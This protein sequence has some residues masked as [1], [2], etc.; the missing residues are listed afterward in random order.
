M[1]KQEYKRKLYIIAAGLSSRMGGYPKHLCYIDEAGT[2]NLE[3]TLYFAK[4]FYDNIVIVINKLL[5]EEYVLKTKDIANKYNAEV[6]QIESG[7]GDGHAVYEAI[8]DENEFKYVTCIWGDTYFTDN[9]IFRIY[10]T[11]QV[12]NVV[13]ANEISPYCYIKLNDFSNEIESM[14]FA[15]EIPPKANTKYLHDQSTFFINVHNFKLYFD[16]YIKYCDKKIKDLLI[17][18][19]K[20]EYSIIKFVNWYNS[21]YFLD[22]SSKIC[23]HVLPEE[24]NKLYTISYNTKEE[25]QEILEKITLKFEDNEKISSD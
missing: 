14:M 23:T 18:I 3:H 2:T 20:F 8:K 4:Y 1:K 25:L 19:N 13:S 15:N 6:K 22:D 7:K 12:L 21:K 24:L 10:E 5:S 16:K 17:K 9:T 11:P